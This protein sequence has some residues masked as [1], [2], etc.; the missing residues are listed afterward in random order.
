MEPRAARREILGD[1]MREN[2]ERKGK[3]VSHEHGLRG[4]P[5]HGLKTIRQGK[6]SIV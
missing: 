1:L 6:V 4:K 2:T 3:R 5:E